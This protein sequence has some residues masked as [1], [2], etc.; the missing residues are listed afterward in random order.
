MI[1]FHKHVFHN[2]SKNVDLNRLYLLDPCLGDVQI[3]T[4][5]Y[6]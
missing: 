3:V 5:A 2:I 6:S 4:L 1:R